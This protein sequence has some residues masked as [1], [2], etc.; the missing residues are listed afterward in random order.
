M[1]GIIGSV[2]SGITGIGKQYLKNKKAVKQAKADLKIATLE[3]KARLMNSKQQYNQTWE[4]AALK[5]T[6]QF[7]RVA[8]FTMFAGPICMNM[9]FP[10]FNLDSTLMWIGLE[11]CPD[12]WVKCFTVMNGTIWGCMEL[13]EMGGLKGI[14]GSG[15]HVRDK[16]GGASEKIAALADRTELDKWFDELD[17]VMTTETKD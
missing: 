9:F 11:S 10:Y 13:R 8:S 16:D 5:E 2:I 17:E 1:L 7:L 12:W 6:P 3:N 15:K 14:M 4:I